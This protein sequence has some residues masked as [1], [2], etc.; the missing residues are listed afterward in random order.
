MAKAEGEL[1]NLREELKRVQETKYD[2]ATKHDAAVQKMECK[3]ADLEIIVQNWTAQKESATV[4][5][6]KAK[7]DCSNLNLKVQELT[8]TKMAKIS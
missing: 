5:A 8:S 7:L 6:A 3:I 1:E 4:S 2:D